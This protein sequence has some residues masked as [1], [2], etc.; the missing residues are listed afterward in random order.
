MDPVDFASLQ[1]RGGGGA[2]GHDC[3]LD[4]IDIHPLAAGEEIRGFVARDVFVVFHPGGLRAGDPVF[5]DELERA[6]ADRLGD[7]FERVGLRDAFRH[8]EAAGHTERI[9][10]V[11]NGFF[12][13]MHEALVIQRRHFLG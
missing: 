10:V 1:R 3:V 13:W 7:L 5:L 8:D 2:V 12:R 4:A 9:Q 6:G 11:E